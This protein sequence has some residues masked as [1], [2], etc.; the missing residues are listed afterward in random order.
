MASSQIDSLAILIE[1][2]T[3]VEAVPQPSPSNIKI[4]FKKGALSPKVTD[5][6]A[7][8]DMAASDL[9]IRLSPESEKKRK[10]VEEDTGLEDDE[11]VVSD[12]SISHGT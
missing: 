12:I 10:A 2:A 3:R 1:A 6:G 11:H 4:R 7:G 8:Q 9:S 5:A